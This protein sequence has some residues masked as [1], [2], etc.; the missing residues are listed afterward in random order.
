MS[1]FN[2]VALKVYNLNYLVT[3]ITIKCG[4]QKCPFLFSP[5]KKVPTDFLEMPAK[6]ENY[7]HAK[8]TYNMYGSPSTPMTKE[9]PLA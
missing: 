8:E 6:V 4:R 3:M 9:R 5:K 7:V 2:E 1:W